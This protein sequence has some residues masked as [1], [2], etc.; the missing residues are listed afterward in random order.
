MQIRFKNIVLNSYTRIA[1]TL[2][3][4]ITLFCQISNSYSQNRLVFNNNS[5]IVMNN[6]CYLVI[7]NISSNA[8][9]LLGTGGNIISESEFN[10]IKWNIGTATGTY[11]I[12]FTKS[13]S[14]KIPFGI[15][16]STGGTGS[17]SILFSTYGGN[18]DNSLYMP[19][20]VVSMINEG[21]NNNSDFVIDRF[22]IVDAVDY[23]VKPTLSLNFTYLD[24][25]WSVANNTIS[26]T[27]L[28]AQQYNSTDNTWWGYLPQG[29][30]DIN[31]NTISAVPVDPSYFF[32]SWTLVDNSSPLPIELIEFNAKCD[33]LNEEITEVY[34]Y[35]QTA[36]ENNNDYFVLEKSIDAINWVELANIDGAGNSNILLNYD[37][38]D[39]LT[40]FDAQLSTLYY[41]LKQ[42]DFNGNFSYSNIITTYCS[43][44]IIEIISIYPNPTDNYF[45][46]DIFST[47]DREIIIS[48]INVL[49]EN[50]ICEYKEIKAGINNYTLNF[51]AIAS[52]VYYFK[53]ETA[54]RQNY[55]SKQITIK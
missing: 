26:E 21:G 18:W 5:Y 2:L 4:L 9:T 8:I 43:N 42:V 1:M 35:W 3:F 48:I 30:V 22:W 25:E 41:R 6:S 23:T 19:S 10:I 13:P 24:S 14:N 12:P 29:V 17:G 50:I 55:D 53:I 54:D 11:T 31:S 20:D 40:S 51:S 45:K 16:I 7:D 34:V 28:G 38:A 36:S 33:R 47:I 32:R 15:N 49:G 27:N 44:N 52:G 39:Q 37:Y 46:Y